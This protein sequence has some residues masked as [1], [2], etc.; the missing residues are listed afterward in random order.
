MTPLKFLPLCYV[1]TLTPFDTMSG[2]YRG[3][4]RICER[5]CPKHYAHAHNV[6]GRGPGGLTR[7]T[8]RE[9]E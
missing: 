2:V 1:T 9:S 6:S 5:G 4:S 3:V 8:N 7:A